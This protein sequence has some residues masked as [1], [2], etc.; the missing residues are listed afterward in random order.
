MCVCIF[1]FKPLCFSCVLPHH[2]VSFLLLRLPEVALII[3]VTEEDDE[4][5]AVTNHHSI[6]GIRVVAI[7]EQVVRCVHNDQDKLHLERRHSSDRFN[8]SNMLVRTF[9][10]ISLQSWRRSPAAEMSGTVSTTGISA[11]EGRVQPGHSKSTL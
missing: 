4:G 7:C 2:G 9:L 6:H 1:F 5:D 8:D 10:N 3:K 11:C